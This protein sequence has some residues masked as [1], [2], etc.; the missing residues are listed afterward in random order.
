MEA[1]KATQSAVEG[2][3]LPTSTVPEVDDVVR[4]EADSAVVTATLPSLK[5][6]PSNLYRSNND[7]IQHSIKTFLSR[8]MLLTTSNW[9]I[10]NPVGERLWEATFPEG[11]L[12]VPLVADKLRGF[13]GFRA[14]TVVRVQVNAQRMQQGRLLL[15]YCPLPNE[16]LSATPLRA[17]RIRNSLF[18]K[19]CLPHVD[20]DTSSMSD[21]VLSAPF[22]SPSLF[23]SMSGGG[24]SLAGFHL[25][26]YS[27]LSSLGSSSCEYTVWAHFEDVELFWPTDPNA[28]NTSAQLVH[29]MGSPA[30][31][32]AA[33][34][35]KGPVETAATVVFDVSQALS[36]VPLLS[37]VAK[38]VSW[39]AQAAARI[40]KFFG[41]SKPTDSSPA[42]TVAIVPYQGICNADGVD[43]S[44]KLALF[45][46][47]CVQALPGFGGSDRDE[48]AISAI[49]SRYAYFTRFTWKN[50]QSMDIPL[51]QCHVSPRV[52]SLV[53]D[54]GGSLEYGPMGYVSSMFDFWRGSIR[55]LFKFVKTEFHSGRVVIA[56]SPGTGY[57]VSRQGIEYCYKTIVDLRLTDTVEFIVPFA[58]DACFNSA[59]QAT[60]TIHVFVLNSLAAPDNVPSSLDVIVETSAGSD[61]QVASPSAYLSAL[62]RDPL[63]H[64]MDVES[65]AFSFDHPKYAIGEVVLSLRPLLKR[66][67]LVMKGTGPGAVIRPSDYYLRARIFDFYNLI[68][69]CFL[70]ARGSY[71]VKLLTTSNEHVYATS[72]VHACSAATP[73]DYLQVD[74]LTEPFAQT[75]C[76]P[77]L[78]GVIEVEL[79][80]YNR[81]HSYVPADNGSYGNYNAFGSYQNLYV[82]GEVKDVYRA[83]GDDF[84]VGFFLLPPLLKSPNVF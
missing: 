28:F 82:Q 5:Q 23:Y 56:F 37:S 57:F 43:R 32:E 65:P 79:P 36:N 53:S 20:L 13:L 63:E 81:Y 58:S 77:P 59:S 52:A 34:K 61:F 50:T 1:I 40:A 70:L 75:V 29:Q 80:Q 17:V 12:S 35:G 46:D 67:N 72:K 33:S 11:L 78:S 60:G 69:P 15:S 47:N 64:Q 7:H 45:S 9:D 24:P 31:S 62:L 27:P 10:S 73:Y 25:S 76:Y 8:P 19:T 68:M 6:L 83:V 21:A 42:Q 4:F 41:W 84:D 18:A 55:F 49:A 71:R 26:V 22:V 51:F 54:S 44:A 74:G 16:V 3:V 38:P 39:A 66:F 30:E 48:L 2:V 14:T